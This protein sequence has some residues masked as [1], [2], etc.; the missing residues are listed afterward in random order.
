MKYM[1]LYFVFIYALTFPAAWAENRVM[2]NQ[3][4]LE[5]GDGEG[6]ERFY[7]GRVSVYGEL[8]DNNFL[9]FDLERMHFKE[10]E[11]NAFTSYFIHRADQHMWALGYKY[12]DLDVFES[13]HAI[14]HYQYDQDDFLTIVATLGYEDKN[15]ADNHR[16]GALYLRMYPY[17]NLMV[18]TGPSI[19]Y[20]QSEDFGSE[21]VELDLA[22][23]W[24]PGYVSMPWFTVYY[25][26]NV[27]GDRSVGVRFRLDKASLRTLQRSGGI[28]IN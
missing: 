4:E 13:S 1:F 28:I 21:D 9:Q 8:V 16:Y 24:Q 26:E 14:F 18:Q 6:D 3:L 20:S 17:E 25:Q 27:F 5:Y 15:I 2:L 11:M 23:E 10:A 7:S 19:Y 22:F 12:Q